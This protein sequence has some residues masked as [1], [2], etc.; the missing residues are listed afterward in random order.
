MLIG[1]GLY[2]CSDDDGVLKDTDPDTQ[3]ETYIVNKQI[4]DKMKAN[5]LWLDEISDM[6]NYNMK[7][8]PETFFYNLISQN[9]TKERNGDT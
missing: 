8:D 3:S 6:S 1:A 7:A 5:Y 9:E 2:S 4:F